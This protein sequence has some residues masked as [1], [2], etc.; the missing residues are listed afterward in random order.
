MFGAYL[1]RRFRSR[2]QT[3]DAATWIRRGVDATYTQFTQGQGVEQQDL[4]WI[5][6]TTQTRG[7]SSGGYV[8]S[9]LL[10]QATN[11]QDSRNLFNIY[12]DAIVNYVVEN[13]VDIDEDML[14]LWKALEPDDSDILD[15]EELKQKYGMQQD[16]FIDRDFVAN[17]FKSRAVALG[18]RPEVVIRRYLE[19]T[20]GVW[21]IYRISTPRLDAL[22][23]NFD[24][25]KIN[26]SMLR[27]RPF[28]FL[29][30]LDRSTPRFIHEFNSDSDGAKLMKV[31][32]HT[33]PMSQKFNFIGR[34]RVG[35]S[36]VVAFSW[37]EPEGWET[38]DHAPLARTFGLSMGTNSA[39]A[40]I[41]YYS[42][43]DYIPGSRM[44][45]SAAFDAAVESLKGAIGQV[46]S[47]EDLACHVAAAIEKASQHSGVS[48]ELSDYQTPTKDEIHD[49]FDRS[50]QHI[51]FR[52]L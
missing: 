39:R 52:S 25:C 43:A 14:P 48:A 49:L 45:D 41:A 46:D 27:V 34:S 13:N 31:E 4:D 35:N 38:D 9:N 33:F 51:V 44:A 21:F 10:H 11:E 17:S 20:S 32:G 42:I 22:P 36:S 8:V 16:H 1:S 40:Q 47:C 7:S 18:L 26:V 29:F 3:K 28:D 30:Q 6:L 24:E 19:A 15:T 50:R 2:D 23:S 5:P 12:R 37:P